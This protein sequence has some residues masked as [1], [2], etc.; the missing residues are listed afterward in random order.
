VVLEDVHVKSMEVVEEEMVLA[1]VQQEVVAEV[2]ESDEF[3]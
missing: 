3:L 1:D 2:A